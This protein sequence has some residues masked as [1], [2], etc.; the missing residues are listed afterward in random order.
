MSANDKFKDVNA[1]IEKF[2]AMK[3]QEKMDLSSDQDLSIAIM[4]LISIEEHLIFSGAKTGKTHFYDLV[5]EVREMRKNLLKTIIKEYEGEV[6]C[7]SK[8][9]LSASMRLM[10][11]GT[12]AQSMGKR[13]DAYGY[14]EKAY[15]LYAL[16]WG[17]QM[18]VIGPDTLKTEAG[19]DAEEIRK[20]SSENSAVE[21]RPLEDETPNAAANGATPRRTGF[22]GKLGDL[23]RKAVDCC[24]E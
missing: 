19:I 21:I 13:E 4:N 6:W 10:E 11:V 14:F 12:K 22:M 15:D 9:L 3:K 24:I 16:F 7:I 5:E 17:L 2:D 20:S 18:K 23:V 8:H 1:L